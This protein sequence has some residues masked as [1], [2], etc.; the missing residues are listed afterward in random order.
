[1]RLKVTVDYERCQANGLC[2][3]AAPEIFD[4]HDDDD[5]VRLLQESPGEEFRSQVDQVVLMCPTRALNIED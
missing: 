4:M 1:M 3:Q 2:T 5:Q